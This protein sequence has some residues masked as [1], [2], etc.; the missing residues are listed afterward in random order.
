VLAVLYTSQLSVITTRNH[1]GLAVF[2]LSDAAGPTIR[3]KL[4]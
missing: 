1:V 2:Y 3:G 4:C